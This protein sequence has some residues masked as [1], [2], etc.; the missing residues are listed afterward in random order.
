[1]NSRGGESTIHEWSDPDL[2]S[3]WSETG[4]FIRLLTDPDPQH[5]IA[6]LYCRIRIAKTQI[7][8][9]CCAMFSIVQHVSTHTV[10]S[11]VYTNLYFIPIRNIG[12]LQYLVTKGGTY[13]KKNWATN[14]I[15][16]WSSS[17]PTP[18]TTPI[19]DIKEYHQIGAPIFTKIVWQLPLSSSVSKK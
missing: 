13:C 15:V 19:T 12:K 8:Q 2:I 7:F 1:M 9:T 4:T 3:Y 6:V 14:S 10:Y 11:T 18:P 5:S 16:V 17:S